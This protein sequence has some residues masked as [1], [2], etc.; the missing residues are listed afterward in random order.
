MR[1]YLKVFGYFR[2]TALMFIRRRNQFL[3]SSKY[4]NR[5]ENLSSSPRICDTWKSFFTYGMRCSRWQSWQPLLFTIF[6]AST[7]AIYISSHKTT[8]ISTQNMRHERA[9]YTNPKLFNHDA[10]MKTEHRALHVRWQR[11]KR[12]E[13]FSINISCR[14]ALMNGIF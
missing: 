10:T 3:I 12:F 8:D 5:I 2:N 14:A 9:F 7:N 13:T 11:L 6:V 1:K 4:R